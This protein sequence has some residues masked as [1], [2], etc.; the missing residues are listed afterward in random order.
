MIQA[1]RSRVR[2]SMRSLAFSTYLSFQPHY[3]LGVDSASNR[4][5]YQESSCGVNGGRLVRLTTSSPSVSRLYRKCGSLD[6]SKPYG[7]PRP[8][9]GIALPFT[10]TCFVSLPHTVN[11]RSRLKLNNILYTISLSFPPPMVSPLY[12]GGGV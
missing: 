10:N 8:L 9:T 5:E 11:L 7:L 2:F 4:N 12:R 6:V 3:D 1:G